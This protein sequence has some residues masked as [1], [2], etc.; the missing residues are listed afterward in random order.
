VPRAA[1]QFLRR[2]SAAAR[3]RYLGAIEGAPGHASPQVYDLLL[4]EA[5]VGI[6]RGDC[7]DAGAMK[8]RADP[9][10]RVAPF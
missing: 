1:L 10:I 9:A 5:L 8:T 7:G 6:P 3:G 2:S 4:G